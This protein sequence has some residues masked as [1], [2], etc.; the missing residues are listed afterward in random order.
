MVD[1]TFFFLSP[2]YGRDLLFPLVYIYLGFG[3]HLRKTQEGDILLLCNVAGIR[4]ISGAYLY[5]HYSR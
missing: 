1:T 4:R 5:H 3:M 2:G